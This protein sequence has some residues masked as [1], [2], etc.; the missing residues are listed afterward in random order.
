VSVSEQFSIPMVNASV[1]IAFGCARVFFCVCVKQ[2][3]NQR[4]SG[5]VAFGLV[6]IYL[7][8]KGCIRD[9]ISA[10]CWHTISDTVL[11]DEIRLMYLASPS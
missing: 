3:I 10:F 1:P 5:S 7:Y 11:Y 6:I 4:V 9:C 8:Y 2:Q